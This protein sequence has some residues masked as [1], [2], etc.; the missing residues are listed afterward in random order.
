MDAP[1]S[2]NRRHILDVAG[3]SPILNS[4]NAVEAAKALTREF[5]EDAAMAAQLR[6]AQSRARDNAVTYCH[7]REVERLLGWMA[8][9]E[10]LMSAG[11]TRH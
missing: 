3:Y 2:A 10:T 7:W 11:A 9:G 5:G 1:T 8:D 4:R 6:A